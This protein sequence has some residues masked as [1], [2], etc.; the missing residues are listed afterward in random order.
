VRAKI[1]YKKGNNQKA[2][3]DFWSYLPHFKF[4]I[5]KKF[6]GAFLVISLLPIIIYTAYTT[7]TIKSLRNNIVDHVKSTF[8][9]KTQ[10]TME[11]QATVAAQAVQRFLQQRVNDLEYF[12]K[13]KPDSV[14]YKQF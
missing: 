12:E 13:L 4:G 5:F 14:D 1:T 6:L 10:E 8:D 9:K 2:A 3:K 7:I 11:M